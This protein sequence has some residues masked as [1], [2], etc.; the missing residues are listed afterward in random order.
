MWLRWLNSTLDQSGA[1]MRPSLHEERILQL[2]AWIAEETDAAVPAK[3]V[4]RIPAI[5]KAQ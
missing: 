3:A 4:P 2:A 1:R 5:Q